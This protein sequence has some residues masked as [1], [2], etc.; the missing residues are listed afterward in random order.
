M[1]NYRPL[2]ENVVQQNDMINKN[3]QSMNEYYST[4]KQ[5]NTYA[6]D[7]NNSINMYKKYIIILYYIFIF[8]ICCYLVYRKKI[9]I[10][11]FLCVVLLII[12]PHLLFFIETILLHYIHK[13]SSI[14]LYM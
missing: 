7:I 4:D 14:S 12:V 11:F 8:L 5:K 2:I 1:I 10:F 13:Y 9:Q 6:I 3:I